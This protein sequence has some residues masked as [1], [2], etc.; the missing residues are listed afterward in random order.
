MLEAEKR[1][2]VVAYERERGMGLGLVLTGRMDPQTCT[3]ASPG[4]CWKCKRSGPPL[5]I[6]DSETQGVGPAICL[7]SPPGAS[8]AWSDLRR[9]SLLQYDVMA[10]Y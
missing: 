1:Y 4:H 5:L 8:T 7:T 6:R 2:E 3:A 10:G 9:S